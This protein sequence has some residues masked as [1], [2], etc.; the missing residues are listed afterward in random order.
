M[1]CSTIAEVLSR[2]IGQKECK[3]GVRKDLFVNNKHSWHVTCEFNSIKHFFN[4]VLVF[5]FLKKTPNVK[6]D[7]DFNSSS[8]KWHDTI[9]LLWATNKF[10]QESNFQTF[11]SS[12]DEKRQQN[13]KSKLSRY[14]WP[15]KSLSGAKKIENCKLTTWDK[16]KLHSIKLCRW[17][18]CRASNRAYPGSSNWVESRSRR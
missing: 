13:E 9:T 11:V 17:L 2:K 8:E 14:N 1:G 12:R 5:G 16:L 15:K 6:T 4:Q 18:R 3:S 10:L 7:S